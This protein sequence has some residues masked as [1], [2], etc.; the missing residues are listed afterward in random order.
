MNYMTSNGC[1]VSPYKADNGKTSPGIALSSRVYLAG[2]DA[3]I[4]E[5]RTLYLTSQISL[6][7]PSGPIQYNNVVLPVCGLPL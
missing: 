5:D 2:G 6:S 7:V 3:L 4:L 1:Y